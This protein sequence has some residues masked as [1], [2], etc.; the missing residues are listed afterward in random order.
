V[1]DKQCEDLAEDFAEHSCSN[2][3]FFGKRKLLAAG[4]RLVLKEQLPAT[5]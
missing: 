4:E 5:A 3:V 2:S 1:T